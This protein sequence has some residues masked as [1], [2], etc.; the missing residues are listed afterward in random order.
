MPKFTKWVSLFCALLFTTSTFAS[1]DLELSMTADKTNV[2]IYKNLIY[3]LI[4]QNN[5]NEAATG[6]KIEFP[7]PENT[8]YTSSTTSKGNYAL[9]TKTWSINKLAVGESATLELIVFTLIKDKPFK[10][11][12]QVIAA[13]QSD[14][15]STP[16]NNTLFS[17]I[18]DDEALAVVNE[19][20]NN[21]RPNIYPK[22]ARYTGQGN[23]ASIYLTCEIQ[24]NGQA[25][26]PNGIY[27]VYAS[28]DQT[29]S[30]DD[31][32]IAS[33]QMPAVNV[34]QTIEFSTIAQGLTEPIGEYY[35]IWVM[36]SNNTIEETNESDNQYFVRITRAAN[37]TSQ[38]Y[39]LQQFG[40]GF[41]L[42][43]VENSTGYELVTQFTG[44]EKNYTF[45][46]VSKTGNLTDS[47]LPLQITAEY[48]GKVFKRINNG[49][50]EFGN[51]DE[52]T[53]YIAKRNENAAIVWLQ[54]YQLDSSL[55]LQAVDIEATADNG[56]IATGSVF[57]KDQ[58]IYQGNTLDRITEHPFALKVNANGNQ[59]W[60]NFYQTQIGITGL[61]FYYESGLQI[62]Q[63]QNGAYVIAANRR[64]ANPNGHPL[65]FSNGSSVSI[66]QIDANGNQTNV[67]GGAGQLGAF[68][69]VSELIPTND[70]GYV[71]LHLLNYVGN[72]GQIAFATKGGGTQSWEYARS[73][74]KFGTAYF[75][76]V[77]ETNDGG[78]M[79][80]GD[81][82]D[83]AAPNNPPANFFKLD[84]NGVEEWTNFIGKV[85]NVLIQ[86]SDGGFLMAGSKEGEVFAARLDSETN[87]TPPIQTEGVDIE[88]QY[89]ADRKIYRQ[90]ERVNYTLTATN[91]GTEKATNLVISDPIPFGMAFT[92][93]TVSK[94][95]YNL[96]FQT[97]T[98]P[99]LAAGETATLN[100]VL[101]TLFN[102]AQIVKFAQV[103]SLDQMDI[104][105]TPN[106]NNT[107]IP[108]ED[109]ET[110]VK[111][112]PVNFGSGSG[113]DVLENPIAASNTLK[114]YQMFPIP[115]DDYLNV[116]FGTDGFQVNLLLYDVN[117]RLIQQKSLQVNRGENA[118]QLEVGD[119]AVGFYTISLETP[120]GFVR[121][122]FLKR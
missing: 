35:L 85:G 29:V 45:A 105:S 99:E 115:A 97:W 93:K 23:N 92:S 102:D 69:S 120:E 98:I 117:G 104:D 67:E 75:N 17:P 118:L 41:P 12:A 83:F 80:V 111:I 87:L 24:N 3:T 86:T 106:N 50:V 42:Q 62:V 119:L 76:D 110:A 10:G 19:G 13:D 108:N 68:T 81:Y 94:G 65:S 112:T 16:N 73:G 47:P 9:W 61:D 95:T 20:S 27:T 88:L 15:D 6:V 90:W 60:F 82:I 44:S 25:N 48:E 46:N 114:I 28:T 53:L 34:G 66:Y 64:V 79:L 36:D 21:L 100:L 57:V 5:G 26:A 31:R 11:F 49:F 43:L 18:E 1:I 54:E 113:K 55:E 71:Y 70:D 58:V 116:V 109:D 2:E 63:R 101:F 74:S 38:T 8:A 14:S 4:I 22:N 40:T 89:T 122:K 84:E 52:N 32:I 33:T 96:W 30:S 56:F 121:G 107:K 51:K 7:L 77:V 78:Y 91:T 72:G 39:F 37:E 103:K 59:Q